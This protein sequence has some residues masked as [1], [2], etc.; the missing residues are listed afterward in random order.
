MSKETDAYLKGW[1][2]GWHM[3]GQAHRKAFINLIKT[4][5]CGEESEKCKTPLYCVGLDALIKKV[6]EIVN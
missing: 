5:K 2:Q 3:S 6:E 1:E 4:L